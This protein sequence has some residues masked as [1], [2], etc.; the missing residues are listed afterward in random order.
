MNNEDNKQLD[1]LSIFHYVLG[2]ITFLFS[3]M[4]FI[5]VLMG[6]AMLCGKFGEGSKGSEPPAFMGWMFVIMGAVFI[7]LGWSLA[8]CMI[9]AGRKLKKRRSRM[10]CM[11]F[12]GIECI[13][14]PLGT[15]LGIFTIIVLS[16]DSVK[17][18]FVEP[19]RDGSGLMTEP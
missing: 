15:V 9:V 7:L 2:G 18:L 13:F 4:P 11:V 5:H 10:F 19:K 16:K 12:A 8:G 6:V 14:M 1:L 3:C 17:E